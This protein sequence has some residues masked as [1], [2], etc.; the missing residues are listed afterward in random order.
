VDDSSA[1]RDK[2]R[3]NSDRAAYDSGAVNPCWSGRKANGVKAHGSER[4]ALNGQFVPEANQE[5]PLLAPKAENGPEQPS[6]AC[7]FTQM[8]LPAH[9]SRD[10]TLGEDRSRIRCNPGVFARIANRT[11]T[12]SQDRYRAALGGFDALARLLHISR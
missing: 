3:S 11:G 10:V 5:W 6:L 12:F 9:Y 8:G 4:H 7:S 2:A 1:R